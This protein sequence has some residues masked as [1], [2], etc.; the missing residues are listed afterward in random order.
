MDETRVDRILETG[1]YVDDLARAKRFYLELFG[2]DV[3]LE[4]DRLVAFDV[5]GK[6]VLL[7]FQRGESDQ[8]ME[9]PG[10]FI[11]GHGA[12]GIQHFAFAID[13]NQIGPWE[14][15]LAARGIAIESR[16]CW[17]RGSQS[18]YFRDPDGHSLELAT[19]GLWRND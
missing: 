11:P 4:S 10:G 7:L 17:D 19:P 6:S 18:L 15:K 9:A 2:F 5:A 3:L 14:K 12:S 8:T 16:V 13:P 1:L